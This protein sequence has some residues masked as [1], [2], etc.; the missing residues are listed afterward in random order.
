MLQHVRLFYQSIVKLKTVSR[1][2][3]VQYLPTQFIHAFLFCLESESKVI[4]ETSP[5]K[6]VPKKSI[7]STD[8][9]LNDSATRLVFSYHFLNRSD[10]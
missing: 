2:F 7:K 6:T 8:T 5:S 1:T 10:A 4:I 9:S 3:C